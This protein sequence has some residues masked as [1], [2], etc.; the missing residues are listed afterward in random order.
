MGLVSDIQIYVIFP[1]FILVLIFLLILDYMIIFSIFLGYYA[2]CNGYF[3]KS[4][5]IN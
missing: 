2:T 4:I 3:I 5:Y 1:L